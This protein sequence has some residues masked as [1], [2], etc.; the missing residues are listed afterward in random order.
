MRRNCLLSLLGLLLGGCLPE[1][2]PAPPANPPPLASDVDVAVERGLRWLATAQ[3]RVGAWVGDV[4]HKRQ[5]SYLIYVSAEDQRQRGRGH[6][7]LTALAGLAFLANGHVPD[8]G[9]HHEVLA[10]AI[11]YLLSCGDG[12]AY[13]TDCETRMYSHAFAVLFLAQVHGM[14]RSRAAEVAEKLRDSTRFIVQAQNR[15]GAWRYAPG[16]DEAD[17]SV[18]V[19]QVQA[20]RAA[21]NIGIPVPKS[22]IDRVVDYVLESRIEYGADA[23][24]FYYKIHGRGARTRTT[25]AV[26]AAAVTSLHSAG[27]YDARRYSRALEVIETGYDEVSQWYPNHFYFWYGNYYAAQAMNF[28][29][30]EKGERY[31]AKVTRDLLRRQQPDGSW[32][33]DVGPGDAFATAVACLILRVRLGYLPIFQK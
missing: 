15:H 5:D 26:N 8:R 3:T 17:L 16:S 27:I 22:T 28:E 12:Y 6:P 9:P 25:F 29:G 7:G 13:V 2:T 20:L 14:T 23:G 1:A 19:C 30:G 4:G 32:H 21:R 10:S 24:A 33:N 31:F 11:E 18:T